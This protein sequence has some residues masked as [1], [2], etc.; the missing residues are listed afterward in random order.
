MES[1]LSIEKRERIPHAD[2]IVVAT[3]YLYRNYKS[4]ES[5]QIRQTSDTDGIRGD[6]AIEVLKNAIKCGVRVVASEGGSSEDFL[7]SLERF[8]TQGLSLVASDSPDR[9]PQRRSAFNKAISLPNALAIVYTQPEKVGLM[10]FL[11]EITRPIL[12]GEA[13]IVIPKR[14]DQLFEETYPDYMRESE[15]KVNKRYDWMMRSAGLI[16]KNDH[17]DWFFGPVVFKNTPEVSSLFFKKYEATFSDPDQHSDGH[18]FPIIEALFNNKKVVGVEVPFSYPQTQ[19]DNEMNPESMP[20][21]NE[22][23][24]QD[25]DDYS[26]EALHLRAFIRGFEG[27][28]I[29]PK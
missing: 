3:N 19:K 6:L 20:R 10:N 24:K 8:T 17:F 25:A 7:S 22:R 9:G 2:Q 23:R 1:G 28:K 4:L 21:F 27:S 15:L 16:G 26:R 29:E 14:E 12:E 5:G 13:D 11:E 18:Y